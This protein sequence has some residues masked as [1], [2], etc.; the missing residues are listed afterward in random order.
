MWAIGVILYEMIQGKTPWY[1]V[2]EKELYH[3]IVVKPITK[4]LDDIPVQCRDFI[5]GVLNFDPKERLSPG[6]ALEWLNYFLE[7]V[8]NEE[9][10]IIEISEQKPQPA[11]KVKANTNEIELSFCKSLS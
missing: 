3:K 11:A 5:K 4:M 9:K 10:S 1:A 2:D 6:E 8:E 7:I